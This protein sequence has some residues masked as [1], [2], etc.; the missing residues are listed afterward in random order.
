MVYYDLTR[1]DSFVDQIAELCAEAARFGIIVNEK[2]K[3]EFKKMWVVTYKN[4][5]GEF[6][7]PFGNQKTAI[8]FMNTM[9]AT[10]QAKEA[11]IRSTER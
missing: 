10:G 9:L 2:A 4:D 11:K 5:I 1:T 6:S 8:E 3:V 7:E